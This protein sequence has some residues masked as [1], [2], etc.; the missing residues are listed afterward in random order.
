[1]L[2]KDWRKD[3]LTIP[4]MLSLFRLLLIPVYVVIY[5]NAETLAEHLVAG[6]I[7]A[8]SCLTDMIDGQIARHFNMISTIGKLL[9]PLADKFTQ[10]AMIICLTIKYPY[11]ILR[12]FLAVFVAKEILQFIALILSFRKGKL[13]KGA[14]IAGKVSTTL[15]FLSLIAMVMIPQMEETVVNII[16]IVDAVALLTAFVQ[17]AVAYFTKGAILEQVN[18]DEENNI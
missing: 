15:L 12:I 3:L 5:L 16:M 11:T 6:A 18:K 13:P 10:F 14:L 4:N 7:L 8:V 1:M 2:I 17:Y 9:D